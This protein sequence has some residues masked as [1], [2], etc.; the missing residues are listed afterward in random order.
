MVISEAIRDD[1][2][3]SSPET[4]AKKGPKRKKERYVIIRVMVEYANYMQEPT[5]A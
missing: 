4:S 5:E 1:P 3:F 2:E